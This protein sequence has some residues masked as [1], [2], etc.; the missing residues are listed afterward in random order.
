MQYNHILSVKKV[1]KPLLSVLVKTLVFI[2]A[3]FY[4]LY[5]VRFTDKIT[6]EFIHSIGQLYLTFKYLLIIPILLFFVNWALEALKW[7]YSIKRIETISFLRSFR[8]VLTGVTLGFATPFNLGDYAGRILQLN[9]HERAKG[10]GAVFVNR[11]AQFYMT[12]LFGSFSFFYILHYLDSGSSNDD[13]FTYELKVLLIALNLLFALLLIF[14]KRILTFIQQIPIL[15]KIYPYLQIIGNY[16]NKEL[17]Y[18][19][20]LSFLRYLVFSFQ[21]LI[22][23]YLFGVSTDLLLLFVGVN[24]IFFMKSVV[25]TFF[26]L[27]VRESAAIYFFTLANCSAQYALIA[28]ISLWFINILIPAMIGLF[29]IFRIKL[30]T[31][32]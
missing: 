27:G 30:F 4:I 23:L 11:I 12:L 25:P 24:F 21:F 13:L 9:D 3:A 19:F 1:R 26:D 17:I 29:L 8:G 6:D 20:S 5:V 18:L 14:H 10:I 32:S 16:S 22:L 15:Q 28:S 31:Q 2:F 7:K